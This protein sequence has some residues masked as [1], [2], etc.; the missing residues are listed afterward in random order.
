[1]SVSFVDVAFVLM[2]II[3][4][5]QVDDRASSEGYDCEC[6]QQKTIHKLGQQAP[7]VTP[8]MVLALR[9]L[10]RDVQRVSVVENFAS[11][12]RKCKRLR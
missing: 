9:L 1:M 4:R 6:G 3:I 10:S 5:D 2:Y 7:L 11:I 12:V 8:P